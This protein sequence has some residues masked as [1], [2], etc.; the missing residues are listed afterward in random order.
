MGHMTCNNETVNCQIPWA[1]N[2]H[3]QNHDVKQ[4]TV[5]CYPRNVDHCCTWAEHAVEDGLMLLLDFKHIFQNLSLNLNI[6][7]NLALGNINILRKQ[8]SLFHSNILVKFLSPLW[9]VYK[10]P[11]TFSSGSSPWFVY[12]YMISPIRSWTNAVPIENR[13]TLLILQTCNTTE[14]KKKTTWQCLLWSSECK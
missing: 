13:L 7:L 10:V 8:N 2:C 6:S 3:C 11:N 9:L 4:E 12:L 5:H 1:G 14:K